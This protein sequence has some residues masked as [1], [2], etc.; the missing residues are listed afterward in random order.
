MSG[1]PQLDNELPTGRDSHEWVKKWNER[2]KELE[3]G[4][5]D[6]IC[7]EVLT[8]F[9]PSLLKGRTFWHM[10]QE[11]PIFR[12]S[13]WET[14]Q[15]RYKRTLLPS[16][17][18]HPKWV[19]KTLY[20]LPWQP[21]ASAHGGTW[22]YDCPACPRPFRCRQEGTGWEATRNR[23]CSYT[24]ILHFFWA[25][26]APGYFPEGE[27][28]GSPWPG[29]LPHTFASCWNIGQNSQRCEE[30]AAHIRGELGWEW[31]PNESRHLPEPVCCDFSCFLGRRFSSPRLKFITQGWPNPPDPVGGV[32]WGWFT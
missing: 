18:N 15:G 16:F 10:R 12:E 4:L 31:V 22:M 7:T 13:C 25:L 6:Y 11:R 21:L 3:P 20:S 1:S 26:G 17:P 23:S 29:W 30:H 24:W 9:A 5:S 32:G 14:L 28:L 8:H 19:N 2:K 27:H